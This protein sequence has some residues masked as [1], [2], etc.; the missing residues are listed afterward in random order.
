MTPERLDELEIPLMVRRTPRG[1]RPRSACRSRRTAGRR[2]AFRPP[3]GR[4]PS[5]TAIDPATK[6]SDLARPGH[7][8][9]LRARTGGVHGP[10]RPDR[11]RR[12]PGADCRAV[13]RRRH[14]RNHERRRHDGARAAAREVR[15]ETRAA[16]D[17]DRGSDQVPDPHRVARQARRHGEAADRV[18][19]VSDSRVR[20]PAGQPDARRARAAATSATGKTCWCA[21]TRRA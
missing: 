16:D 1:S 8:F 15:Q 20:K 19:D 2:P 3:I 9:P 6:P 12:R 14:L 17:H 7:M 21:S 4:R 11:G 18:R 13:S 5:L 10:R